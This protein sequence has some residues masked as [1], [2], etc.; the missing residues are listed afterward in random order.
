MGALDDADTVRLKNVVLRRLGAGHDAQALVDAYLTAAQRHAFARTVEIGPVPTSLT[1][2]RSGLLLE[3]SRE[4]GRVVDD[5]EIQALFRVSRSQA[6]AMRT[7][8]LASYSDITDDLTVY[9][10]LKDASNGGRKKVGDVNGT[11]VR[12]SSEQKLEA[13]L[14]QMERL[15]VPTE[16]MTDSR[17]GWAVVVSDAFDRQRLP[18]RR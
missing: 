18:S 4:L 7:T 1:V 13:F 16:T 2:E 15:G 12:L 9:W 6:R 5:A 11:L 17:S 3:I 10:A 14:S 8:L